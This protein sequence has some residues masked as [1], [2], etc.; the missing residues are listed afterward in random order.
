MASEISSGVSKFANDT[1]KGRLMRSSSDSDA[2]PL[3]TDM[4]K[5]YEWA[6]R[7]QILANAKCLA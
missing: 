3:Q 2:I 6:N 1:K 7:F 5:M 4:E